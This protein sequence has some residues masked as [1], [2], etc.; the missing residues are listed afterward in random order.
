[1]G[2]HDLHDLGT[3]DAGLG[4]SPRGRAAQPRG[5]ARTMT[6]LTVLCRTSISMARLS[7]STGPL[8]PVP[9]AAR[10]LGG[11][12]R[13]REGEW[14]REGGEEGGGAEVSHRSIPWHVPLRA[15]P[16]AAWPFS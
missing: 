1:M 3:T 14:L 5:A 15:A 4:A 9:S 2:V 16:A 8:C 13:R 6:S 7:R 11:R 10:L 12:Q